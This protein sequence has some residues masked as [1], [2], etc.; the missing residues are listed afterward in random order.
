MN[1]RAT[2]AAKVNVARGMKIKTNN[3]SMACVNIFLYE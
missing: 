1:M 3:T 2:P